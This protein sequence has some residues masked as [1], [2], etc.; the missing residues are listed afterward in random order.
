MT[1]IKSKL[2]DGRF[3]GNEGS[4]SS[5]RGVALVPTH[6]VQPT[7]SLKPR[8]RYPRIPGKYP[9]VPDKYQRVPGKYPRVPT[10]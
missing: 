4:A 1:K 7:S 8:K 3:G 2:P 5:G 6:K 9:R 10:P